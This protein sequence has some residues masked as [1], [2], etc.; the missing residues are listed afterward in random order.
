ML[1]EVNHRTLRNVAAD[2]NTYCSA[3]NREMRRADTEVKA[4]LTSGWIGQDAR[5]F[6]NKWKD[7]NGRG[8]TA[9]KFHE[10]LKNYAEALVACA[11]L[12]QTAQA[13]TVNAAGLLM[14]IAGR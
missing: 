14:R 6:S 12:Y 11:D 9:V 10:S 3:Q 7:V 1:I 5:E 13:D 2:I 4:M 8:S